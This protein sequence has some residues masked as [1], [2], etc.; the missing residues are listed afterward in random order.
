LHR[1]ILGIIE[2]QP[3]GAI[4][5]RLL[6]RLGL[7]LDLTPEIGEPVVHHSFTTWKWSKTNVAEGRWERTALM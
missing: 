2:Q 5:Y 7:A 1:G 3:A 4:E 6:L